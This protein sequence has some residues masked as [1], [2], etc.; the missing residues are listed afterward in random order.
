MHATADR[1][2]HAAEPPGYHVHLPPLTKRRLE[3][4]LAGMFVDFTTDSNGVHFELYPVRYSFLLHGPTKETLI[5]RSDYADDFPHY[6]SRKRIREEVDRWN[7][8]SMWPKAYTHVCQG[9]HLHVYGELCMDYRL[10]VTDNQLAVHA[11]TI[12]NHA[13]QM[14]EE[15]SQAVA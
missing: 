8:A 9:G 14:Y 5:V 3:V 6:A 10:G 12:V 4:L 13:E 1:Y 11:S 7:Q 15:I 2:T